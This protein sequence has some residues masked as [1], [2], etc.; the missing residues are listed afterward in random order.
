MANYG[1][2]DLAGLFGDKYSTQATL[3][4]AMLREAHS[5]GQLSSYGMG[6]ASTYYQ[7]AGGGTPL[8][9]M[10]TQQ[11]PMMQRQKILDAIQKAF[12]NPDTPQELN[13]LAAELAKNGFGDMAMK[14][15]QAAME[16]QAVKTSSAAAKLAAQTPSDAAF[17]NLQTSLSNKMVTKEMVHGYLQHGQWDNEA[18]DK[19]GAWGSDFIMGDTDRD[20]P[21]HTQYL[22]D[23]EQAEKE[24][25]GEIENW[26]IDFQAQGSTKSILNQ[27]ILNPDMQVSEFEKFVDI[28]GNTAA[29]K[30]LAD[31]TF[32][33]SSVKA[34][35]LKLA[36]DKS[37]SIGMDA[38][39]GAPALPVPNLTTT[40]QT[41]AMNQQPRSWVDDLQEYYNAIPI[42][43][44]DRI[45]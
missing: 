7:A 44:T 32:V 29:G 25:K 1:Y 2:G 17:T 3:N 31:Q 20:S 10:L 34:D 39:S 11:H 45:V 19:Y 30:F 15:R 23:Y 9:S 36:E 37:V 28:K 18:G 38:L 27:L 43:S 5:M 12:P 21:W 42:Q 40:G 22:Y 41:M 8:G 6:Q 13:K 14:V 4:D 33:I 26:A 24:L 35:R 16:L